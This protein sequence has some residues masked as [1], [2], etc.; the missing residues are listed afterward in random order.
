M[1]TTVTY[2][3]VSRDN[4]QAILPCTSNQLDI[5]NNTVE[6]LKKQPNK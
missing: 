3:I 6:C 2:E 4:L 1:S 5:L